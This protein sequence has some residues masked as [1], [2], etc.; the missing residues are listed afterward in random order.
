[1]EEDKNRIPEDRDVAVVCSA[2]R[3]F[4]GKLE[5][6]RDH[7]PREDLLE[8]IKSGGGFLELDE[9]FEVFVSVN[10]MKMMQGGE[11]ERMV[12]LVPTHEHA[13]GARHVPV[14]VDSGYLM[15]NQH[16]KDRGLL[17]RYENALLG[18]ASQRTGLSLAKDMPNVPPPGGKG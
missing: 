14:K 8:T 12:L 2:G 3:T 18:S 16:T 11:L 5:L 10:P 4:I 15:K 1:M 7:D 9:V 13:T 6:T 17:R